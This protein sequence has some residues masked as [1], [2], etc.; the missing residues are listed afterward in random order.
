MQ[1]KTVM[2]CL[3][4]EAENSKGNRSQLSFILSWFNAFSPPM[5]GTLVLFY[6]WSTCIFVCVHLTTKY[7]SL[8]SCKSLSPLP[9][10]I[11]SHSLRANTTSND[12]KL[13]AFAVKFMKS[14]RHIQSIHAS[15][16]YEVSEN[17]GWKNQASFLKE[18][19]LY[20]NRF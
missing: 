14:A 6:A 17:Q 13:I 10:F 16:E 18:I 1:Q 9:L 8:T 19:S 3:R 20:M 12:N 4:K 2:K 5:C 15:K 7:S 11:F